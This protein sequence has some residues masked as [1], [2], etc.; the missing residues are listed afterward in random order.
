MDSLQR[1]R[2]I[3]IEATKKAIKDSVQ[4]D[5]LVMQATT[6]LETLQKTTN[7]LVEKLREWHSLYNPEFSHAT[8]NN[9]EFAITLT[10]QNN[11]EMGGNLTAQDIQAINE[12]AKTVNKLF[13]QIKQTE[14]Y[15]KIT[16]EKICP[17]TLAIAG[18]QTTAK[19]LTLAGGLKKLAQM[20]SSKIQML[21]AEKALLRH[22]KQGTKSPKFGIL[23]GH[24]L[25]QKAPRQQKGKIARK[26]A[27][28]IAIAARVDYFKGK[29]I[30]DK[31]K[32]QI[33]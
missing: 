8:K 6:T 14:T 1:L 5:T 23:F 19:L 20:P 30:A 2:E 3:N 25:V 7:S 28:K 26:L 33:K 31:L 13:E 22:I 11:G 4:Q 16:L 15:I 18:A 17:N 12:L 10:L 32:E 21:G 24:Q 27:D 9:E 29:F